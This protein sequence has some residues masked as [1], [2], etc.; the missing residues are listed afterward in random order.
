MAAKVVTIAMPLAYKAAVDALTAISHHRCSRS[1][2]AS[3]CDALHPDPRLRY[4]A[5]FDDRLRAASRRAVH[6]IGQHAT[7]VLS[8]DTF[9]HVHD[10]SLRFHLERKTGGL[11]R[12]LERGKIAIDLIIRMGVLNLIPTILEVVVRVPCFSAFIS[13]GS[14]WPSFS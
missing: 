4:R 12:V 3:G 6:R 5:H 10:L 13:A 11:S 1:D 8:T 7:R 14:S 9:R 2:A